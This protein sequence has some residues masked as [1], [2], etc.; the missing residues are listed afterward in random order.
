MSIHLLTDKQLIDSYLSG[1]HSSLEVL[2]QRHKKRLYSYIHMKVK[3]VHLAEDLFQDTFIKVIGLLRK[4][5]YK[6]EGRFINWLMRVAHNY[7]CDH[8]KISNR[9]KYCELKKDMDNSTGIDLFEPSVEFGMISAQNIY[10]LKEMIDKL[11][12]TQKEVLILRH[13]YNMSFKEIAAAN[14]VSLS[15]TLAR[16]R[17][18]LNK[19]RKLMEQKK[20]TLAA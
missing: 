4:G 19:L 1:D 7:M 12:F 2:I 9:I 8:Y 16:M 15:T 5:K 11:P 17:Y 14:N 6:D 18:A 13:Y 3:N 20:V 10:Q